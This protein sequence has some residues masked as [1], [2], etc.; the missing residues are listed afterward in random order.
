MLQSR[1]VE[2]NKNQLFILQI[3]LPIRAAVNGV[4]IANAKISSFFLI[5]IKL[6]QLSTLLLLVVRQLFDIHASTD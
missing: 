4:I 5:Q 1:Q 6:S 2:F 3:K